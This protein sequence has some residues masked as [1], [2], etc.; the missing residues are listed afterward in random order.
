MLALSSALCLFSCRNQRRQNK[1][2]LPTLHCGLLRQFHLSQVS[3][4]LCG[5]KGIHFHGQSVLLDLTG[6]ELC[7]FQSIQLQ[8]QLLDVAHWG[9]TWAQSRALRLVRVSLQERNAL[10]TF[11]CAQEMEEMRWVRT[12]RGVV[13]KGGVLLGVHCV[14]CALGAAIL[15]LCFTASMEAASLWR[16]AGSQSWC[17]R[18]TGCILAAGRCCCCAVPGPEQSCVGA[19]F[20]FGPRNVLLTRGFCVGHLRGERGAALW[21]P[22]LQ[23]GFG[24]VQS[25]WSLM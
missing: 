3:A 15:V 1:A 7:C 4:W 9:E 20:P 11:W 10:G 6:R 23:S 5:Y 18:S 12:E 14:F 16:T 17:R 2:S 24:A 21:S 19:G 22:C 8:P 25:C 13:L